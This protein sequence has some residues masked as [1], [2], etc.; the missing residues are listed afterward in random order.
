[1]LVTTFGVHMFPFLNCS[2]DF[3]SLDFDCE[4]KRGS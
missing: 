2:Y 1:M 3:L 4:G